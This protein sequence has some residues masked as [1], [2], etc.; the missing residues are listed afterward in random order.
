MGES[1][2]NVIRGGRD[3]YVLHHLLIS[4]QEGVGW[5]FSFIWAV[6]V[7]A[8]Y[9]IQNKVLACC[10]LLECS[11]LFSMIRYITANVD[12]AQGPCFD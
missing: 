12:L 4:M 3:F 10:L 6:S 8:N 11:L 7:D 5:L 9:L 2:D 1:K